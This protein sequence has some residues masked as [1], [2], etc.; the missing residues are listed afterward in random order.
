MRIFLYVSLFFVLVFTEPL[1]CSGVRSNISYS[2][3]TIR[4]WKPVFDTGFSKGLFR[5]AM[6]IGK[7]HLT[8]FIFIKKVSD[9]SFRVL[10][11]NEI[12]MKFFDLEF[13]PSAFI[14]HYCFPSLDRK[15][16]LKLLE[17]DFR[18]VFFT[19]TGIKKMKK[20]KGEKEDTVIYTVKSD[21]GKWNIHVS[22]A[23]KEIIFI[24]SS[25]RFISK[26]RI[27]LGY[28]DGS[29]SEINI[30]NPLIRLIITMNLISR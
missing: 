17:N 10:F 2:P 14:V 6:D 9:T 18:I 27:N 1:H 22:D 12:G 23:M 19:G 11:S 16:L 8:G 29:L 25:G 7:N 5:T 20:S 13:F 30:S 28:S 24:G 21:S 4:E 15:S 26:T 3:D